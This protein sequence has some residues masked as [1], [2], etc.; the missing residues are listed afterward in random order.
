MNKFIPNSFQI[1]NALVDEY[2]SCMSC[3]ATKCFIFIC[4]KTRGWQKNTD[5]ISVS[6]FQKFLNIK[7]ERTVKKALKE[8]ININL[9]LSKQQLGKPTLYTLVDNPKP[10]A[11]NVPPLNVGGTKNAPTLNEGTTPY[12][13]CTPQKTIQKEEKEEEYLNIEK[14]INKILNCDTNFEVFAHEFYDHIHPKNKKSNQQ[15]LWY[16]NKVKLNI[17]KSDKDTLINIKNFLECQD[18][19]QF[20]YQQEQK[21]KKD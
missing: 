6:Q 5:A 8:L 15:K 20:S 1:S 12:I 21:R 13:F 3:N 4:R 14:F 19:Q 17:L 7:D 11:K 18:Q 2:L 9:I 10:P 16:A